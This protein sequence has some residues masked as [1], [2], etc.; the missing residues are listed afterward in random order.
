MLIALIEDGI[1]IT[2]RRLRGSFSVADP[3]VKGGA[4]ESQ[5]DGSP[6][7]LSAYIFVRVE[8]YPSRAG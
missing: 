2:S 5:R 3:A 1:M 7:A 8:R 4:R 6:D